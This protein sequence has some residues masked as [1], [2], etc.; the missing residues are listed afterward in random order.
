MSPP[1]K[2]SREALELYFLENPKW[3]PT[4]YA[5]LRRTFNVHKS[6]LTEAFKRHGIWPPVK[7]SQ[8][9]L[10]DYLHSHPGARVSDLMVFFDASHNATL[11]ALRRFGLVHLV[12]LRSYTKIN[13]QALKEY[14]TDHP[15]ATI[16][17]IA[18]A[19]NYPYHATYK[20]I[21]RLKSPVKNKRGRPRKK[22]SVAASE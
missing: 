3:T 16:P 13:D 10:E 11:F 18:T 6:T 17:V 12:N 9:S 22:I 19:F 5:D 21:C 8:Q 1:F 7:I 14:L 20:A 4:M 2:I 15:D